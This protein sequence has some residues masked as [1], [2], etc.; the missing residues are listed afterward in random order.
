[1]KRETGIYAYSALVKVFTHRICRGGW[2]VCE[3]LNPRSV[4]ITVTLICI[5]FITP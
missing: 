4:C 3:H 2:P 1:M 5:I